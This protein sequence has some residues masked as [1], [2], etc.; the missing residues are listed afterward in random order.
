[1]QTFR[2]VEA[3]ANRGLEAAELLL[4]NGFFNQAVAR[5]PRPHSEVRRNIMAIEPANKEYQAPQGL[6]VLLLELAQRFGV[7][8]IQSGTMVYA[9][10]QQSSWELRV[11]QEKMDEA[12]QFV[13]DLL[14]RIE[15]QYRENYA[16]RVL[17]A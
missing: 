13:T 12:S 16:V 2:D 17:A 7:D 15:D 8:A 4:D 9:L 6:M 10:E 11:P 5:E 1:M 14:L 3:L